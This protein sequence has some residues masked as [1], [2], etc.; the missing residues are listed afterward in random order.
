MI[1]VIFIIALIF[2]LIFVVGIDV[3]LSKHSKLKPEEVDATERLVDI[4]LDVSE[5]IIYFMSKYSIDRKEFCKKLNITNDTLLVW[6][7]GMYDFKLSQLTRIEAMF[8]E[9]LIKTTLINRK[10]VKV[11]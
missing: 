2:S 5:Q 9:H 11:Y 6:L 8:N 7:S 4:S 1:T 10:R 3:I